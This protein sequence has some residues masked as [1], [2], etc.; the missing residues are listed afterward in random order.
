MG[1][2]ILNIEFV[3]KENIGDVVKD[4]FNLIWELEADE[5]QI[6]DCKFA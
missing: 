5:V 2:V 3:E 4:F 1:I 6:W